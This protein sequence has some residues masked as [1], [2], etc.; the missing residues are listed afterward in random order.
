[1]KK[2]LFLLDGMALIY[3]AYFAFIRNPMINSNGVETSGVFGFMNT[4]LEIIDKQEPTHLA[5]ALDVSGPTFRH[6]MFEE[7]KAHRDETPDGI[8]TAIP[9]ICEML[10]AMNIPVL[11]KQGY[12]A[13]D[14]IGTLARQA[15]KEGFDTYM[16][17]GDKDYAQLVDK[18]T[19]FYKP[20]SKGSGV[21]ILDE[22]AILEEWE[23]ERVDQ[24]IDILGLAG[25]S[26]DNIP[27]VPGIGPKTAKKL[28]AQFGTIENLLENTDQLKGKQKEKVEDNKTTA[29]LCK[30][31][32][33]IN[34]DVPIDEKPADL[35]C[36]EP[37]AEKLQALLQ[38][39]EL[40]AI[41][42]RLFGSS[43]P[44]PA[45]G[46]LFSAAA[47]APKK[48]AK[49][50]AGPV[51]GDLFAFGESEEEEE[52]QP[53]APAFQ[54]IKDVK[55]TY[56]LVEQL[57][58]IDSVVKALKDTKEF[59]FDTETTSLDPKEAELVGIS[60]A[61][62]EH[63]AWYIHFPGD[64]T[65]AR[66]SKLR[67]LFENAKQAKIGHN[68]KYDI[69]VLKWQGVEVRGPLLD[70]MLAH[71]LI[72]PDQRHNM[73][74]LAEAE[75]G[76][77]TV[78]ITELIGEKKGQ[79]LSMRDVPLNKVKEYAA[80]DADI[81]LQLW[82]K[83]KPQLKEHNLEKVFYEIESPLVH[84]LSEMESLGVM[85]N[86]ATLENYSVALGNQIA[87]LEKDIYTMA[88]AEFN[89]NSPKQLG[90][91]LFDVL[92]LVEKPKKTKTGQYAT[93]EQVLTEL[94]S[95][96]DIVQK[97]LDYR[98]LTKLK[99]T[100]VDALPQCISEK[101][102]RIHT[103]FAQ[104][105]TTT[106]RLSSTDPNL[107]NIPVRT[108]EGQ[109]I[110]RAFTAPLSDSDNVRI[111]ACDYSQVELRLMAELS[112][113]ENMRAAFI[114]GEDI[115]TATAARVYGVE[116]EEV[117]KEMRRKAKMVNFGIIYGI[118]AFGLSQRLKIPRK[119]A[120]EM[121]E[122]YFKQY[123]GV[124]KYMDDTIQFARD[125]GYVET[126]TGRR[127]YIRD[128]HV[129]N[130][131]VRQAAERNAINAPL[132]GTAADMIK[133]AMIK[134]QQMLEEWHT[135]TRMILQVHDELIFELHMDEADELVPKIENLMR[136][137]I[138]MEI[139]LLVESGMGANWLEAH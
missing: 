59:C 42:R 70:T 125:H 127:R 119:E 73:D 138:P 20:G 86:V 126:V 113:D 48:A 109:E 55:H 98:G 31:L 116:L 75:L 78:H 83:L 5:V 66:L 137:A 97:V 9:I 87:E 1:M 6:E 72:D 74:H 133:I 117:T 85:I 130:N 38:Q 3:R 13:D 67:P 129:K 131:T 8:R 37:D 76:Y 120:A 36:K 54:T 89:L 105:V 30:K 68:L 128:I 27:G 71:Y 19:F 101:T 14:I 82:N 139:P 103:N 91:I 2:K 22:A 4:L 50:K 41:Q 96:H 102:G 111:L 34:C 88:G 61:I 106:G 107:Q 46:D 47:A 24:V 44:A 16:V 124:K 57:D 118:S 108:P 58:D 132:Q 39:Y 92:K 18:H 60:F 28:I 93:S 53:T 11:T 35:E 122:A 29:Q 32:V 104:A 10:E 112:G 114:H 77:R 110:R 12:E 81:T 40:S 94:A 90:E 63:E 136:T 26:A 79:Q 69:S 52:T 62:K 64:D 135:K 134:I 123:P 17:T 45:Q 33:T 121:I 95:E 100:Y 7:Y 43:T 51:Q 25:D 84:V 115:H 23:I 80:E 56:T 49:K 99:N 15:E 65:E 21:T